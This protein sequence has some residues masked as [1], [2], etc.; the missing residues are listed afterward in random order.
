MRDALS[1]L[2]LYEFAGK[3]SLNSSYQYVVKFFSKC[4]SKKSDEAKQILDSILLYNVVDVK[5]S[6]YLFIKNVYVSQPSSPLYKLLQT[7]VINKVFS[8][9]FSPV[10]QSALKDEVGINILLRSFIEKICNG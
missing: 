8:F 10:A 9:F 7:G 4:L 3:E 6:I 1:Y 5:N 2:Q